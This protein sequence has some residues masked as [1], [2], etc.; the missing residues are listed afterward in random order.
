[1]PGGG[2]CSCQGALVLV[3]RLVSA[4]S[5]FLAPQTP[6]HRGWDSEKDQHGNW[7]GRIHIGKFPDLSNLISAAFG[8]PSSPASGLRQPYKWGLRS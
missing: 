8:L 5:G 4:D 3:L 7:R 2:V 1:M 6:N